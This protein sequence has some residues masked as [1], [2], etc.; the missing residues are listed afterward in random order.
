MKP[1]R[2]HPGAQAE[3][4]A[5]AHYYEDRQPGLGK[6]YLNAV[7]TAVRR[8]QLLPN[9]FQKIE[10]E[11]RRCRVESFPYGI[12]FRERDEYIEILAVMHFKRAPDYWKA[13]G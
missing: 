8:I 13:R 11:I 12:I 2:F 10:G 1:I 7:H 5:S 3:L 9:S 4:L 6:R